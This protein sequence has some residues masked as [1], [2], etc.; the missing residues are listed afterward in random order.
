MQPLLPPQNPPNARQQEAP[1]SPQPE[2]AGSLPSRW[3]TAVANV[4]QMADSLDK[5]ARALD[6]AL[7]LDDDEWQKALPVHKYNM[8]I[9]VGGKLLQLCGQLQ[10]SL[11]CYAHLHQQLQIAPGVHHWACKWTCSLPCATL[12]RASS[13][14]EGNKFGL[15]YRCSTSAL[16]S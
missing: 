16:V 14:A 13:S 2:A 1:S 6:G 5:L 11:G 15:L 3:Q 10:C 7:F 12:W 9:Q 4:E 8:A